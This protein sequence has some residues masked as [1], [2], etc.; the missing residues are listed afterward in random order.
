MA[1]ERSDTEISKIAKEVAKKTEAI[2][3][4]PGTSVISKSTLIPLGL[5][6]SG[7]GGFLVAF[8]FILQMSFEIRELRKDMGELAEK[9]EEKVS[10]RS[11]DR[12]RGSD[13]KHWRNMLEATNPDLRVPKVESHHN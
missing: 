12:W 11:D 13:M 10:I 6:I 9:I 3:K 8:A 5:V 2:Q 7:V 4:E 1:K